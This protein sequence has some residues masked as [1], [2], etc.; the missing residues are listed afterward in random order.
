[1]IL[2]FSVLADGVVNR[3]C[4]V[5]RV[6][7]D[8]Q[9]GLWTLAGRQI[10]IDAD[11]EGGG[12]FDCGA[13]MIVLGQLF[14]VV[15]VPAEEVGGGGHIVGQVGG[16]RAAVAGG[17]HL[18]GGGHGV[19]RS[20]GRHA[21]RA[22]TTG[23]I[24]VALH[25][26]G[27][28]GAR[29]A[30][31]IHCVAVFGAQHGGVVRVVVAIPTALCAV[32]ANGGGQDDL[33]GT[34]AGGVLGGNGRDFRHRIHGDGHG[35]ASVLAAGV[36]VARHIVGRV[37]GQVGLVAET[38]LEGL[39]A[40]FIRVPA[41]SVAV[42]AFG[43]RQVEG[44]GTASGEGSGG[45]GRHTRLRVHGHGQRDDAVTTFGIH[46]CDGLHAGGGDFRACV[47]VRQLVAAQ[48]EVVREG[49]TV[50][51]GEVDGHQAVATLLARQMLG[52]DLRG[53]VGLA[54]PHELVADGGVDADGVAVVDGQMQR[55]GAVAAVHALQGLGVVAAL[56]VGGSFPSVGTAGGLRVADVRIDGV[57]RDGHRDE[58][59][60]A[61]VAVDDG[62]VERRGCR[63]MLVGGCCSVAI[64]VGVP[65]RRVGGLFAEDDV[66]FAADTRVGHGRGIGQRVDDDLHRRLRALA[67]GAVVGDGGV[68]GGGADIHGFRHLVALSGALLVAVVPFHG[69]T[70][71]CGGVEGDAHAAVGAD[72]RG[73]VGGDGRGGRDV[74]HRDGH[75]DEGAAA[76]VAVD[77]GGVERRGCRDMLVGGCCSVAILVGIPVRRVVGLVA[78]DDVVFSTNT[79][80][81]DGRDGRQRV[82][83]GGH[84]HAGGVASAGVLGAHVIG[85][86]VAE[87]RGREGGAVA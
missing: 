83:G 84:W 46:Q 26:E 25:V 70:G 3:L 45:D 62:G 10:V 13:V 57:R 56:G 47:R 28:G 23:G 67:Q 69:V 20:G 37:L 30:V 18:R 38:G 36:V 7:G 2:I 75:R 12:L 76:V 61:V 9:R 71:R 11:Q 79:H 14:L 33:A 51:H 59:A 31:E 73:Q 72:R 78:E 86:A 19:L 44:A 81:V 15:V 68:I 35:D 5:G 66:A 8:G 17:G 65:I 85:G 1:M 63:D 48:H 27:A 40:G 50:F 41:A 64:L 58:G 80:V 39:P 21:G 60:A 22:L 16:K 42:A 24:I 55:H 54:L 82:D 43:D 77:D 87:I 29:V 53:G 52:D 32:L 6:D 4:F 74:V 34:A 49:G